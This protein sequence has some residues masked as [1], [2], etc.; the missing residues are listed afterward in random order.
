MNAAC[1]G[2]IRP[3]ASSAIMEAQKLAAKDA[4][5]KIFAEADIFN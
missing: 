4:V 1:F 5:G 3:F 2:P